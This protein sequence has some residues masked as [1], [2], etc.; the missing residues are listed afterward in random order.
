MTTHL[1]KCNIVLHNMVQLI[2]VSDSII[3][4]HGETKWIISLHGAI[5][6][7]NV[8]QHGGIIKFCIAQHGEI[9]KSR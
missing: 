2:T 1:S 8:A 9:T 3:A 4:Q 6:K 7:S 5:S